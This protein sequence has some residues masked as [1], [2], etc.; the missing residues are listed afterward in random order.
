M[1]GELLFSILG[2]LVLLVLSAFF[3]GT[4]TALTAV[5]RARMHQL[6]RR[7]VRHASRVNRLIAKPERL[8]G[9]VLLGNNLVN[10]LASAVAT[11]IMIALFGKAGVAYATAIMTAL[12]VIFAEVLPKTVALSRPDRTALAAGPIIGPIV[13]VLGPAVDLVQTIVRAVLG[14]FGLRMRHRE[15]AADAS[16]ELRGALALHARDGAMVKSDRDM[17]DAILDLS[18]VEVSEIMIHRK[19]MVMLDADQPAAEIAEALLATPY[20]R[21]PLWRGDV[22][23][24]VGVL[25]AKDLLRAISDAP[26]DTASYSH[27]G[28]GGG[29]SVG[30]PALPDLWREPWFVPE[31]TTLMEQLNAFRARREHFALVVD[32]YGA[33]MGLVTLEDILEEIVGDISD[34]HDVTRASAVR[35]EAGGS[36]MVDGVVTVRDLNRDFDWD[37]PE[38]DAATIAGLVIHLARHIPDIGERFSLDGFNFEVMRRLRNQVTAVRIRPPKAKS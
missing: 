31:T 34:E 28:V 6:E 16:E 3:S 22:D 37:L 20:S 38:D 26:A 14:L 25:H 9:A 12:V 2:V 27:L 13:F 5:S 36:F 11:S 18:D 15:T 7:G 1:D 19:N 29:I 21:V 8:I 33:L 4:E 17:L 10:I 30:T 32:E 35:R 24:I 23:N